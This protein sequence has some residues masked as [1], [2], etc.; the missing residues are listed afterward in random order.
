ML[1]LHRTKVPHKKGKTNRSA[2][3]LID[4]LK[5][6]AF[7]GSPHMQRSEKELRPTSCYIYICT[8]IE[9]RLIFINVTCYSVHIQNK[10]T[11]INGY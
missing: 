2:C 5:D 8:D 9:F 3:L 7:I 10:H 11:N 4:F 1:R 6:T